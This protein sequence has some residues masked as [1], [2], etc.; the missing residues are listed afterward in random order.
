[1][2]SLFFLLIYMG[3]YIYLEKTYEI[4]AHPKASFFSLDG[5]YMAVERYF[6][7]DCLVFDVS[8]S[9]P[10]LKIQG[11]LYI[12]NFSYESDRIVFLKDYENIK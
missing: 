10:L 4:G 8:K 5:K 7:N 3:Q 1:L 6:F 2:F 12:S 9:N 11:S